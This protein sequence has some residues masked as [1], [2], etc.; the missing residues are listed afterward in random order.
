MWIDEN[1]ADIL[2][3]FAKHEVR[4]LIDGSYALAIHGAPR[5]TKDLDILV[6][7][8]DE[9]APRVIAALQEFGFAGVGLTVEDFNAPGETIQLGYPPLRVDLLTQISGVSF[10]EAWEGRTIAE[11]SGVSAPVLG[12]EQYVANK[13]AVGRLTDLADIERLDQQ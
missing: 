2:R 8:T 3:L 4:F 6:D 13:R 11:F 9:N 1:F 10:G 12:R 5:A 7:A